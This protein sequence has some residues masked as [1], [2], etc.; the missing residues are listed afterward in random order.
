MASSK[1]KPNYMIKAEQACQ[2][3]RNKMAKQNLLQ[4]YRMKMWYLPDDYVPVHVRVQKFH[5]KYPEWAIKTSY[6]LLDNDTVVFQATVLTDTAQEF[7]WTAFGSITKDKAL[8]KIETVSVWRAL[9]FAWFETQSWLASREEMDRFS[10]KKNTKQESN[11]ED[12]PRFNDR[13]FDKMKKAIME[14][15]YE[16]PATSQ[17]LAKEIRKKYKLSKKN[18]ARLDELY[19]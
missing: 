18:A 5:E 17:A 12:K 14:W 4:P 13:D 7:T 19:A 6:E 15:K 8:E 11:D 3:I 1:Q 9:A 10:T 16:P 2:E